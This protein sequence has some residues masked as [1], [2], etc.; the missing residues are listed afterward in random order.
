MSAEGERFYITGGTLPSHAPS[1]IVRQ[2]DKD[3]LQ[4]LHDGEFCYVLNTRQIGKSSLMV[5]AA[6]Q[7]RAE[8]HPVVLLDLTAIGQNVTIEEWYDG[9]LT[10]VAEQLGLRDALEEFW[11]AHER[12]GPMQR[13]MEAIYHAVLESSEQKLFLFIDEIDCVRSLPFSTDEFFVGIREC[14]NRRVWDPTFE[15]LTFCLL[16]VATPADLIADPHLSP[17]NIG[18]RIVLADFTLD[19]ASPLARGLDTA[20]PSRAEIYADGSAASLPVPTSAL[21]PSPE[22]A[23]SLLKQVLAWTGGHPYLTQRLCE[24]LSRAPHP[25]DPRDVERLCTELFLHPQAQNTDDNLAFVRNCLLGGQGE[26]AALLDL[27]RQ[28]RKG[29]KVREKS[30]DPVH[31]M[32]RLSGI[33][34]VT[35]GTL[36]VRNRIYAQVFDAAWL[37]SN[38]PDAELRRERSAYKRGIARAAAVFGSLGILIAALLGLAVVN[39]GH[40]RAAEKKAS[41]LLYIADMNLAQ[42]EWAVGNIAHVRELLQETR[43]SAE[44]N[45]EWGYWTRK[46]R[47]SVSTFARKAGPLAV[48]FSPDEHQVASVTDTGALNIAEVFSGRELLEMPLSGSSYR[49]LAYAPNGARLAM[50]TAQGVQ[51]VEAATGQLV[52]SL[53]TSDGEVEAVT[54][55]PDGRLLLAYDNYGTLFVWDAESGRQRLRTQ[56]HDGPIR[57]FA[58]AQ[59]QFATCGRNGLVQIWALKSLTVVRSIRTEFATS[60]IAL[61]HN[62][63]FLAG[64]GVDGGIEVFETAAGKATLHLRTAKG[65][66]EI[67]FSS[68][69]ACITADH[70]FTR[71]RWDARSGALLSVFKDPLGSARPSALS[72]RDRYAALTAR[73]GEMKVWDTRVPPNPLESSV[74]AAPLWHVQFS[75]DGRRVLVCSTDGSAT[76][77]DA[78][79]G[80]LLQTIHAARARLTSAIFSHSEAYIVTADMNGAVKLWDVV[81]GQLVRS[82]V[83]HTGP[84]NGVLFSPDDRQL[85]TAG[86]DKTTLQWEVATGRLL[87]R[88]TGHADTVEALCLSADGT[89]LVT[90]GDDKKAIVWDVRSQRLLRK[91]GAPGEIWSAAFSPDGKRLALTNLRKTAEIWDTDTGRL[92]TTLRGHTDWVTSLAFSPDGKRIATSSRDGAVKVWEAESGRELLTLQAGPFQISSIAFA[93]DGQRIA[94]VGKDGVMRIWDASPLPLL[95]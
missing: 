62:G 17:F 12:L 91:F 29:R 28:V 58:V 51:I 49:S 52:R 74:S 46:C 68:D 15:R 31:V 59:G 23:A 13:W 85:F 92:L 82:F 19:E 88:F 55:S 93:P 57:A 69:D 1:Y 4:G 32:L 33:V 44:K 54:Y 41:H 86:N 77:W 7:L 64:V 40:A 9:L 47:E 48:A 20:L 90:A 27:Y 56:G 5:R 3:L 25:L 37:Q 35:Q 81:G 18:K 2:A 94:A 26:T 45:I 10:L 43:D 72:G 30:T 84:V 34:K 71:E 22:R 73:D 65:L 11:L 6:Q 70:S 80:R 21:S 76:L 67:A 38:M 66:R 24:A 89:R 63:A 36:Q 53:R 42:R 60:V 50:G 78:R 87:Q 83:G 95:P 8:G 61:S 39:A 14:Y 16:G 79:M 75:R